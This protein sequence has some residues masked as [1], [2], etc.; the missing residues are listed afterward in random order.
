MK[1]NSYGLILNTPKGEEVILSGE[2]DPRKIHRV[3]TGKSFS[4]RVS[5]FGCS[6]NITR[7]N[8]IMRFETLESICLELWLEDAEKE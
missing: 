5:K 4:K 1:N 6:F 7:D 2:K 8:R 3:V